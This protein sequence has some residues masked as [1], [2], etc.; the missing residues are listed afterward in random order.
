MDG[1]PFY[2]HHLIIKLKMRG[3]K[4]DAVTITQTIEDC[5]LD[6]LNPYNTDVSPRLQNERLTG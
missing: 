6:P 3:K 5:L 4:V 2:I 1:I